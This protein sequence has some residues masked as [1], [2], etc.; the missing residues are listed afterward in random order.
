[1]SE[2]EY[3][4]NRCRDL[5]QQLQRMDIRFNNVLNYTGKQTN[6]DRENME[7]ELERVSKQLAQKRNE[8]ELWKQKYENQL[9]QMMQVKSN[10][11]L[12]LQQLSHEV[13]R[14]LEKIDEFERFDYLKDQIM[15]KNQEIE[16][17]TSKLQRVKVDDDAEIQR[18]MRENE[19]LR[20]KINQIELDRQKELEQLRF[21]LEGYHSQTLDNLRK[22]YQNQITV[23]ES[24]IDKFRSLIEIK[25]SEIETLLQQNLKIKQNYENQVNE[26]GQQMNK[27]E[28][29]HKE[30]IN[31][32]QQQIHN[33]NQ[34]IISQYNKNHENTIQ[35]LEKEIKALTIQ[36]ENKMKEIQQINRDKYDQQNYYEKQLSLVNL[37]NES[38][39]TKQVLQENERNSQ[40]VEFE[41]EI[42]KKSKQILEQDSHFKQTISILEQEIV[43]LNEQGQLSN[44]DLDKQIH[45][46]V[47]L[48]RQLE[49]KNQQQINDI[50]N[51]RQQLSE[52]DR[53][54]QLEIEEAKIKLEN[55]NKE[56][57]KL[58]ELKIENL[59]QRITELQTQAPNGQQG[60]IKSQ[61]EEIENLK[62]K[63]VL[64][65]REKYKF[66]EEMKKKFEAS[67]QYQIENLKASFNTQIGILN[68][69]INDYKNQLNQKEA[70]INDLIIKYQQMEKGYR[71]GQM[72]AEE[73]AS[74][75]IYDV[76]VRTK[77]RQGSA[78]KLL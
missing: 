12:E 63:L 32:L 77:N 24:E 10:Y 1:M 13:N 68:Q 41:Q 8:S 9:Q 60:A 5:E 38:L 62:T 73:V 45:Q 55:I 34:H 18:L 23:V 43:R 56:K 25:N 20:H 46:Y 6:Y 2:I 67:N 21:K 48:V 40:I 64:S 36:L 59:Q 76:L 19:N 52:V 66:V 75:N 71:D 28:I 65:E 44:K 47:Y 3:Y 15:D 57:F 22:T 26:M 53:I 78:R 11:E 39:R 16:D 54:K 33:E 27:Q 31:M 37:E 50:Y 74:K 69:E 4:K 51:L 70:Q 58:L 49:D 17:L 72:G 30:Q 61:M 29:F 14:L 35:S 42:Q 7:L